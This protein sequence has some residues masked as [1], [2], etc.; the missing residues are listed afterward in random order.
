MLLT[1]LCGE[2]W[3]DHFFVCVL[4]LCMIWQGKAW[5]GFYARKEFCSLSPVWLERDCKENWVR[6]LHFVCVN[7]LYHCFTAMIRLWQQSAAFFFPG[8]AQL[9][10]VPFS[11]PCSVMRLLS[12]WPKLP[13]F[14]LACPNMQGWLSTEKRIYSPWLSV[15]R[16]T[17]TVQVSKEVIPRSTLTLSV[18]LFVF[19]SGSLCRHRTS[20][21]QMWC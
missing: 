12:P 17:A 9:P 3:T 7:A 4:K 6:V 20:S 15:L 1:T 19:E 10:F 16:E 5:W 2:L 11:A 21:V 18:F 8:S 13:P 14:H